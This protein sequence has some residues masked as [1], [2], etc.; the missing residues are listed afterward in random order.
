[1]CWCGSCKVVLPIIWSLAAEPIILQMKPY[2]TLPCETLKPTSPAGSC[3]GGK[4]FWAK[5]PGSPGT[6]VRCM[7]AFSEGHRRMRLN[8]V[9]HLSNQ[10]PHWVTRGSCS[11]VWCGDDFT[12]TKLRWFEVSPTCKDGSLSE[13]SPIKHC[14]KCWWLHVVFNLYHQSL[15]QLQRNG[16]EWHGGIV[17]CVFG[18]V[19]LTLLSL[20][21]SGWV[22]SFTRLRTLWNEQENA[23]LPT[24]GHPGPTHTH[25]FMRH[26]TCNL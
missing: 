15:N 16:S 8:V 11:W 14:E 10:A 25:M 9:A 24:L 19:H 20:Y 5:E 3:S 12:E 7:K 17:H 22:I 2:G 21:W 26:T 6:S 4:H 13:G 1:M 23:R 18:F